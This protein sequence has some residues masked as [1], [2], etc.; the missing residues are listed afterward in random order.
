MALVAT[1][2]TGIFSMVG[3]GQQRVF[4]CGTWKTPPKESWW[5]G[6]LPRVPYIAPRGL[7]TLPGNVVSFSE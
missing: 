2:V 4:C 3:D 6:K 1:A 7:M 5:G